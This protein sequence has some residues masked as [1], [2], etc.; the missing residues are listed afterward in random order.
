MIFKNSFK[1]I[2]IYMD[3]GKTYFKTKMQYQ[4]NVPRMPVFSF[5]NGVFQPH[6]LPDGVLGIFL[7]TAAFNL[8][9]QIGTVERR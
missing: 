9:H 1:F 2:T 8:T 6:V 5:N 3:I 4:I 7:T